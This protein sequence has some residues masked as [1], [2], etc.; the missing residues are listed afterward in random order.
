MNLI[1]RILL[2]LADKLSTEHNVIGPVEGPCEVSDKGI[3]YLDKEQQW[4]E[5]K[6]G[7]HPS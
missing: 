5:I 2:W 3:T 4:K 6:K 1:A 7:G